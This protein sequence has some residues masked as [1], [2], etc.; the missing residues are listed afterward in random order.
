MFLESPVL[1][2]SHESQ[3]VK[4]SERDDGCEH[5]EERGGPG[6]ASCGVTGERGVGEGEKGVGGSGG[7]CASAACAWEAS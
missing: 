5:S 2:Q 3:A 6:A 7:S 1:C 4:D